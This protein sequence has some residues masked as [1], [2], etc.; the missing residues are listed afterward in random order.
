MSG[1]SFVLV[2]FEI[3]IVVGLVWAMVNEQFFV[4]LENRMFERV[5]AAFRKHRNAKKS[6]N[7]PAQQVSKPV[8]VVSQDDEFS[9]FSPFVA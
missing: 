4:E 5:I 3:A 6:E 8:V 1:I 7:V 2:L 9:R